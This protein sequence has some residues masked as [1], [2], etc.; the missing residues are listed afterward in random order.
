MKRGM[1]LV[2]AGSALALMAIPMAVIAALVAVSMGRPILFRHVRPGLHNA[3]FTMLKFR[4]M[5]DGAGTDAERLTR[6]GRLLRSTSLDELPQLWNVLRGEMSIVGPR[7]LLVEY[8]DRYTPEQ[9]RRHDVK[10]GITGLV[11]V[12]G[13]NALAWEEK[14][15]LDVQY[16]RQRTLALDVR[17]LARTLFQ[18]IGRRGISS[19]GHDTMPGFT[20]TQR[21]S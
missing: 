5:R 17:I 10:P 7:P 20:G 15:A 9:A 14:L 19:A 13:R 8:L 18:V 2:V 4:T 12:S 1:D 16:V 11:Q 6:V 21:T 3:P